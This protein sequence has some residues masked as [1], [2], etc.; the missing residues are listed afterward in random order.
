MLVK[1]SLFPGA[2]FIQ[3]GVLKAIQAL[4]DETIDPRI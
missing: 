4:R 3:L 2:E 1:P